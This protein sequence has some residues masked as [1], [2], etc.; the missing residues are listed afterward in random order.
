MNLNVKTLVQIAIMLMDISLF[1]FYINDSNP[2]AAVNN[3]KYLGG[4][5][6]SN[7]NVSHWAGD[8][9]SV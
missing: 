1:S 4:T 8:Y 6:T 5:T 7:S 2:L 3:C 9:Q